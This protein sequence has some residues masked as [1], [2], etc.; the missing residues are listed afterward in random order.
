MATGASGVA[1]VVIGS[2]V[3]GCIKG[4]GDVIDLI[5]GIAFIIVSV[6]MLYEGLS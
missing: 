1:G 2:L 4:Y 6:R 3:F 5:I